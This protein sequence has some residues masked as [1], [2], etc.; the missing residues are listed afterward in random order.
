MPDTTPNSADREAWRNAARRISIGLRELAHVRAEYDD[1]QCIL[2]FSCAN[3]GAAARWSQAIGSENVESRV[4]VA[5]N[6]VA[7]VQLPC[8]PAAT[9]EEIRHVVLACVKAAH[10]QTGPAIAPGVAAQLDAMFLAEQ[11]WSDVA[12]QLRTLK[13]GF[14]RGRGCRIGMS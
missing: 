9:D 4:I 1:E 14:R 3:A 11:V 10:V 8:R 2:A 5:A 6:G 12:S 7:G 13:T